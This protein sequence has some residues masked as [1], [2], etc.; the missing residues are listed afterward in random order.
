MMRTTSVSTARHRRPRWW[1]WRRAQGEVVTVAQLLRQHHRER[2]FRG[3]ARRGAP[4]P[5]TAG[6][7][8]NQPRRIL[9]MPRAAG[10]A[11]G[12]LHPAPRGA[13]TGP[14]TVSTYWARSASEKTQEA[15]SACPRAVGPSGRLARH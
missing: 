14:T 10:S 12:T 7:P 2:S 15:P 4:A 13:V 5:R 8:G 11:A 9:I 6:S 3:Q 1:Q